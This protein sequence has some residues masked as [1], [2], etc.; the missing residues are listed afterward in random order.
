MSTEKTW[1]VV[2]MECQ[3]LEGVDPCFVVK[4]YFRVDGSEGIHST[5]MTENISLSYV[6]GQSVTPFAELTE[7]QVLDWV[8]TSLGADA[9]AEYEARI[10]RQLASLNV[11]PVIS[12]TM[13]W[14]KFPPY[15]P[16]P[17]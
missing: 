6:A 4:V 17:V 9:V 5:G 14:I 13:P 1:H 16:M 8:K 10:D 15:P 2:R 12:P 3:A 7:T 11:P